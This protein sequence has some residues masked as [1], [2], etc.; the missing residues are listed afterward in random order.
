MSTSDNVIVQ[1]IRREGNEIEIRLAECLGLTG[2]AEVTVGLPH[3]EAAMTDLLGKRPVKLSGRGTYQFK[4]HP[5][6]IVTL[7]LRTRQS[8]PTVSVAKQLL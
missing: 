5:Q 6:Q 7:R 3:S 2:N 4:V 8:A 1:A